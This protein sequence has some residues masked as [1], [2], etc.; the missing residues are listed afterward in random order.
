MHAPAGRADAR[1]QALLERGLAVFVG[2][3][4][5][6]DAGGVFLAEPREPV[7]D[8]H[9]IGGVEQLRRVQHLG[10]RDRGTHVVFHEPLVERVVVAR[11]V[12]QHPLVEIDSLVPEPAHYLPLCCSAG[13]S[14]LTS[15]T[16][17]VPA[18][19][20]V[21]TS[22]RMPSP[23]LYDITCTR[24]TPP[25]IASS[26]ALAFGSMPS[27]IFFSSR[28]F[29]RPA[30]SVSA[31]LDDGSV[32]SARMP[33]APVHSMS[34]SASSAAPMAAA[35]VSPLMLSS[36]PLSSAETGLTIGMRPLSSSLFNTL[37]SI[38]SMS[39]TK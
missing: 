19:S 1:G 34:F 23:D 11:G 17:S 38:A 39:P 2:E 29:S 20:F 16:I 21:K 3:L 26:I 36:V 4:D 18:P 13:V 27:T 8:Q 24:R 30:R 33:G 37:G 14:A 6:P 28:S 35:T 7:A 32:T 31:T 12:P 25:R 5:G 10:V 22:A 9:E 15:A